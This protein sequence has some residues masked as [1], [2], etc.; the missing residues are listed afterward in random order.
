MSNETT[1]L[2]GNLTADP[3]LRQTSSG[4]PVATFTVAS[5]AQVLDGAS[6]AEA[7]RPERAPGAEV[8]AAG[9][10]DVRQRQRPGHAGFRPHVGEA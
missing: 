3:E 8:D 10:L 4:A 2:A 5:T 6:G 7:P 9:V 1:T